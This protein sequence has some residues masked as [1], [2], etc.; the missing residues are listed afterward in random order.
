MKSWE[1]LTSDELNLLEVLYWVA[2]F[3]EVKMV[4]KHKSNVKVNV[5]HGKAMRLDDLYMVQNFNARMKDLNPQISEQAG[6]EL[7]PTWPYEPMRMKYDSS[8]GVNPLRSMLNHLSADGYLEVSE[9]MSDEDVLKS[10]ASG[11]NGLKYD[12]KS[13]SKEGQYRVYVQICREGLVVAEQW[14]AHRKKITAQ[15]EEVD[16]QKAE[17][18]ASKRIERIIGVMGG[19][20]VLVAMLEWDWSEASMIMNVFRFA[21]IGLVV[22]LALVYREAIKTLLGVKPTSKTDKDA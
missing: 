12:F 1:D 19:L 5:G 8:T 16:A 18:E 22:I 6:A 4:K 20:A 14:I 7:V 21:V 9:E 2:M 11:E 3:P 10:L 17:T 15:Q 13:V